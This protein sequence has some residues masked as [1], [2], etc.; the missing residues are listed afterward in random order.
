ML[1]VAEI[2]YDT[3]ATEAVGCK[4]TTIRMWSLQR[5]E[6]I[7]GLLRVRWGHCTTPFATAPLS[8][9]ASGGCDESCALRSR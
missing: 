1:F 7:K 3:A 6:L 4:L 8:R 2:E 9:G 5:H